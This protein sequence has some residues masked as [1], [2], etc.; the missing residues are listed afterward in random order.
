MLIISEAL[1]F[2]FSHVMTQSG[3]PQAVACML[4]SSSL[5]LIHLTTELVSKLLLYLVTTI[6]L[7]P[8]KASVAL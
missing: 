1:P 5:S 4:N 2:F 8:D 7:G 3:L 6:V